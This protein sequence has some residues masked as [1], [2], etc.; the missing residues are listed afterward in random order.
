MSDTIGVMYLGK[1]VEVAPGPRIYDHAAHP[2]TRAL[3]DIIPEPDVDIGRAKRGQHLG[4]ELP[5]AIDPPSGCRFRTRCPHAQQLCA[6]EE[7]PLRS[8]GENHVAACHFPLQEPV[9]G[10]AVQ[11]VPLV[12][13]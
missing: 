7:P 9:V 1:M 3:L 5:S 4:G 11:S 10:A 6:E 12:A 13:V 2:Y 8:F